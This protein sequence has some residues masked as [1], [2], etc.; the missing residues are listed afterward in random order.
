MAKISDLPILAA[1]DVDG[2]ELMPVVKGG[3]TRRTSAAAYFQ[4]IAKPYVDALEDARNAPIARIVLDATSTA[5]ELTAPLPS[6]MTAYFNGQQ[7][8]FFA[9]QVNTGPVT[10]NIGGLGALSMI[11]ERNAPLQAGDLIPN[12]AYLL[13]LSTT[14]VAKIIASHMTPRYLRESPAFTGLPTAPTPGASSNDTRIATTAFVQEQLTRSLRTLAGIAGQNDITANLPVGMSSYV[15][16]QVFMFQ[17]IGGNNTGPVTLN[18]GDLGALPLNDNTGAALQADDLVSQGW[19][20]VRN[21]AGSSFRVIV[22]SPLPRQ[23]IASAVAASGSGAAATRVTAR[24]ASSW[25]PNL[26]PDPYLYAADATVTGPAWSGTLNIVAKQGM[27]CVEIPAQGSTATNRR[28][29]SFLD[30]SALPAGTPLSIGVTIVEK[31][32]PS[33]AGHRLRLYALDASGNLISLGSIAGNDLPGD[34]AYNR[35]LPATAISS[36]Q[37][38][39]ICEGLPLPANVARIA[40]DVRMQD[41]PATYVTGFVARIGSDPSLTTPKGVPAPTAPP[42]FVHV[43]TTGNDSSA[44]T[45]AAPLATLQAAVNKLGGNGSI[46][47]ASGDYMAQRID[48]ATVTGRI[49]IIG[50][51]A[52]APNYDRMPRINLGIKVTGVTKTAGYTK[53]YQATVPNGLPSQL[54]NFNWAYQDGVPDPRTAIAGGDRQPQHRGRSY[55]LADMCKLRTT[56]ATTLSAALAE[57]EA[58]SD[59]DPLAFFDSGILYF[60]IVG[61]GDATAANI[62]LDSYNGLFNAADRETTGAIEIVGLEVRYGGLNLTPFRTAYLD[63]VRVFGSRANA[64]D[65][66]VLRFGTLETAC[67]GSAAGV[68]GDGLNGHSGGKCWGMDLYSHDNQDDGFSDHEGCS[69]RLF[70]GLAEANGGTALAP[71]YGSDHL[72][73]NFVSQRNQAV[74]GRKPAAFTVVGQPSGSNTADD[75]YDTSARWIGCISIGD[76]AGFLDGGTGTSRAVCAACKVIDMADGTTDF[77]FRVAQITDC[78]F[79]S[80]AGTAKHPA[81][82]VRNTTLVA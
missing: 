39:A 14:G 52:A 51:R 7:V 69:S 55:R 8:Y 67:A 56:S 63:E 9:D 37:H 44:G 35:Y 36:P 6:G 3:S 18:I 77:G 65:Y 76:R 15:S 2:S 4:K 53:V 5:D 79:S 17:K 70:G 45:A 61:G 42:A 24:I 81:T 34:S 47:L 75:G 43:A 30:V 80:A 23:L 48:P 72:A 49:A 58:S 33:G 82:T 27:N 19:Y 26:I 73:T 21:I 78:G 1:S 40:L 41:S 64:V 28:W 71:A 31:N 10:L 16:G 20:V 46:Y 11:D 68:A 29:V 60:S 59:T 38:I 32:G 22:P 54:A 57:I 25:S 74:A 50:K 62:Y 13:R 12:V 66:S